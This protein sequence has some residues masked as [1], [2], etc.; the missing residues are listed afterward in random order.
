[1]TKETNKRDKDRRGDRGKIRIERS[2]YG[3]ICAAEL[4][5]SGI[6]LEIPVLH[7]CA[8]REGGGQRAG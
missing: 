3:I 8:L 7:W 5:C 1:M 4:V 2:A 6:T